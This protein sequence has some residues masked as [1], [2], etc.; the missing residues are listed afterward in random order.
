MIDQILHL[1]HELHELEGITTDVDGAYQRLAD[2]ATRLVPGEL[3][4]TEDDIAYLTQLTRRP[5]ISGVDAYISELK[6][7]QDERFNPLMQHIQT[8]ISQTKQQIQ[9]MYDVIHGDKSLFEIDA[10]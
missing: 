7:V 5:D 1:A 2:F 3:G 6:D 4:M 9:D 8:D 10:W